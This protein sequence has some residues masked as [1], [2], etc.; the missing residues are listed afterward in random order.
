MS[1]PPD[2]NNTENQNLYLHRIEANTQRKLAAQKDRDQSVWFGLGMVG[3]IGWSIVIPTVL[4]ALLGIWI[5]KRHGGT[6]SWTLTLL[7]VGL[8]LGCLNAWRWVAEENKEIN[9]K[10][11]D[12]H[13]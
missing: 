12:D 8:T 2:G 10:G 7:L 5:D 13:E 1:K 6:I 3:L 9:R 4:G 11:E